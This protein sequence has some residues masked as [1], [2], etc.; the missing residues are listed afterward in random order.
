MYNYFTLLD[1]LQEMLSAINSLSGC[2]IVFNKKSEIIDMN[3]AAANFLNIKNID[4]YTSN[5]LKLDID[6]E[7]YNIIER[8]LNGEKVY[9]VKFSF[10]CIDSNSVSVYLKVTLFYGLK[11]VFI[12]QF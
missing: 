11:D 3:N 9:N 4:D 7:F 2:C 1:N 12:F 5:K 6:K 8:V 10:K